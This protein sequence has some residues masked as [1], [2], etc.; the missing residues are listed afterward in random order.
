[1]KGVSNN[2]NFAKIDEEVLEYWKQNKTFKKSLDKNK[3]KNH[4]VFYDGPPFATG[5]PHYGHILT[6]Y[7]KDTI[8]RYFTMKGLYVDRRWG[9]DC[10]GLPIE[11]E[12]EKNLNISGKKDIEAFGIDK[13]NEACKN[14]VFKYADEWIQIIERIGRWVDFDRQYRTLDLSF[15]ESVMWAFSEFYKKGLVYESPRVV[16]YCNR[17][18]T[19]LSNFETG[20]DDS[21]REKTDPA[22][23]VRIEAN[24]ETKE[25]FLIWTTT[26]WTLPGN[27][28][29]AVGEDID[30][31]LL[32]NT[33][34][35]CI[36]LQKIASFA[37]KTN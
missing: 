30:Y 31:Q 26:P 24:D 9:W 10:H 8:P 12:I 35:Y 37:T 7:I 27:V 4:Y 33:T 32:K 3:D 6:T 34:M 25:K 13:F 28:V 18:E 23:T 19:P 11:F 21:F 17:C 36:G 15:M 16:P 22:I 5:L 29:I 20:L 2:V 1:M 14:I